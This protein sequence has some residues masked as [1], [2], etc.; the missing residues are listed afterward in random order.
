MTFLWLSARGKG[1]GGGRLWKLGKSWNFSNPKEA[2]RNSDV[3]SQG[4][5]TNQ[6]LTF[7]ISVVLCSIVKGT[8]EMFQ[9]E[10]EKWLYKVKIIKVRPYIYSYSFILWWV[11]MT[12]R[13]LI[14][15]DFYTKWGMTHW[16]VSFQ[17]RRF[18]DF[19]RWNFENGK[20][21]FLTPFGETFLTFLFIHVVLL[22]NFPGQFE[23]CFYP[24]GGGALD[25][26]LTGSCPFLKNLHNP[27]GK[28]FLSL[29]LLH[30][31]RLHKQ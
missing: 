21:F 7:K 16:D 2:R 18:Q 3:Y 26:N 14:I 23:W 11:K 10:R 28:N 4:A 6:I 15:H 17:K 27:F 20:T 29:E 30:Y 24:R 19:I 31:K 5:H 12:K 13:P 8:S 25:C 1:G 9:L 22:K